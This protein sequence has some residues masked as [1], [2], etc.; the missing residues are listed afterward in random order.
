MSVG[1]ALFGSND[2][3]KSRAATGWEWHS[4]Q[5]PKPLRKGGE[6][7]NQANCLDL[8]RCQQRERGI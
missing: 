4:N 6:S 3:W 8:Q 7:P 2:I 1:A 5:E